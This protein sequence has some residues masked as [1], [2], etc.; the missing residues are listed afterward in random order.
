SP[1]LANI[2]DRD[3][4]WAMVFVDDEAVLWLRRDGACA[5][6]AREV[7]YRYLPGGPAGIGP[8]GERA[9]RDSTARAPIRAEIA[10]AIA[11]SPYNGRS[12]VFAGNLALLEARFKDAGA[13]FDEAARQHP[14]ETNV[15]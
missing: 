13:Y 9:L 14:Y 10:R 4:T 8:L 15:L 2:L 6:L 1:M 5:P 3:S 7:A 11:D 12:Q